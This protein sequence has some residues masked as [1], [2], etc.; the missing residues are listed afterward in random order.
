MPLYERLRHRLRF[1]DP[2]GRDHVTKQKR[3]LQEMSG[4]VALGESTTALPMNFG[5]HSPEPQ[6][7]NDGLRTPSSLLRAAAVTVTNGMMAGAAL[8]YA[9]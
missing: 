2:G 5:K 8:N 6:C 1:L 3:I 9:D 7:T 4:N